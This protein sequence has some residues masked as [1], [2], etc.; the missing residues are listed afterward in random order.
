MPHRRF[1]LTLYDISLSRM[2]ESLAG[3][4][5]PSPPYPYIDV[6]YA[7]SETKRMAKYPSTEKAMMV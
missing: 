7:V 5:A 1:R 3:G 6:K 2:V 4:E